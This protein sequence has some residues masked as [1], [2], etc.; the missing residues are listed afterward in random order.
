MRS[1]V[2]YSDVDN[3]D[4]THSDSIQHVRNVRTRSRA[5]HPPPLFYALRIII[6]VPFSFS[7]FISKENKKCDP[8]IFIFIFTWRLLLFFCSHLISGEFV[9]P[10]DSTIMTVY[11]SMLDAGN[12]KKYE[13]SDGRCSISLFE[14]R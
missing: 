13:N 10:F 2:C 9:V 14:R 7:G 4:E 6:I 1:F 12:R 5:W 11:F 8:H 3:A